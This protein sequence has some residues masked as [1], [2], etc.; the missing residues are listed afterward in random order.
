MEIMFGQ[1]SYWQPGT[2]KERARMIVYHAE[3]NN[4]IS[5]GAKR[6]FDYIFISFG[7]VHV[8]DHVLAITADADWVP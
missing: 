4:T 1:W 5:N 2:H 8:F 3:S 7:I 6:Y